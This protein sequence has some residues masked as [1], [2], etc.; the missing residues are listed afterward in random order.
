MTEDMTA[1][2]LRQIARKLTTYADIYTG[3]KE[4][5]RMAERCSEAAAHH[6]GAVATLAEAHAL[7]QETADWLGKLQLDNRYND[8][9]HTERC[10][11]VSKLFHHL[12]HKA[13]RLN[14]ADD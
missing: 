4:A 6:V 11:L 8:L 12:T 9:C 1:E 5:R 3:D 2:E 7:M 10:V 13:E 14:K